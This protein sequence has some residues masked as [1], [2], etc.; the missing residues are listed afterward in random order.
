MLYFSKLD[1]SLRLRILNTYQL[2]M[3]IIGEY[4]HDLGG[5]RN[6]LAVVDMI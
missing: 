1:I 5:K 6:E 2:E 4:S 3:D